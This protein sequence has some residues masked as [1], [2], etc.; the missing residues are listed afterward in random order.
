MLCR[1]WSPVA[2]ALFLV[3]RVATAAETAADATNAT[4]TTES[5]AILYE[6]GVEAY[7]DNRFEE[8]VANLEAAVESYRAY[9]RKLQNC[10]ILCKDEAENSEPLHT[11]NVED[12]RFY[13]KAIRN[14]LC[15]IECQKKSRVLDFYLNR[16]TSDV[17]EE[18]KPYEYLHICYFQ[19]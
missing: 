13:E 12:L 17:F 15:L 3:T 4:A 6:R 16:A 19:V 11:V 1:T 9:T 2:F 7:L 10:R 14:T 5:C 8:C 18:R